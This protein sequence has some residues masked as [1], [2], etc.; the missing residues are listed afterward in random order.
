MVVKQ[1]IAAQL[2][3][4]LNDYPSN[5]LG[6]A[7]E[8]STMQLA[9]AYAPFGNGGYYTKPH[10][11]KKIVY[12]DGHTTENKTPD[13]IAV[14]KDSTAYMVTDILRDVLSKGTGKRAAISGLD[15]A[16]KTG[17]TNFADKNGAKDVWFSGYTTNYTVQFGLVI[18]IDRQ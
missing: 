5:A 3:C 1:L 12:R 15:I 7:D 6:G 9:G 13:S 10:S 2:V 8:F 17:T 14:M 11:I 16:G 18:K 4:P